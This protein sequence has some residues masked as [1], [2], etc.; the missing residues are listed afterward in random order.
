[1][2]NLLV[3]IQ[4]LN[5]TTKNNMKT[6]T[7]YAEKKAKQILN[8]LQG[9]T[10]GIRITAILILLLMGVNNAWATNGTIS[11]GGI[12]YLNSGGSTIWD[13]ASAWFSV[14]FMDANK[15]TTKFVSMTKVTG[16]Y[17]YAT[18]PTGTWTYV[19][20]VR[21]NPTDK[22]ADWTNVW[23]QTADLETQSDKNLYTI[24]G[25]SYGSW[26]TYQPTATGSLVASS[27]N[28]VAKNTNITLTPSIS[29][30]TYNVLKSTSY[31]ISPSSGAT[32]SN[33]TF[34]ATA[35]GSYTVT[36][37]I[38][39]NA[40]G[41]TNITKTATATTTI[42]VKPT[43]TFN[44]NGG[45]GSMSAQTVSYNTNT[46]L[47]ANTFTAPVG[48]TF[49]GWNTKTDGKGTAYA[50]GTSY[51]FTSDLTLYA[52]WAE[53]PVNSHNITYTAQATGWTYG[54]SNPTT[55][56]EDATVTFEVIPTTGYTVTVTSS[57]VSLSN[58]GNIYTFIMPND[59][60]TI[61]VSATAKTYAIEFDN[62]GGEGGPS[63]VTATY[64]AAMPT[65][66]P[67]T[68][69]GY[70][71]NGYFDATSGGTK[72]YNANG[73]S[74]KNWDK[75][76]ATTLYAQWTANKY[77]VKFN[78]N[79]GSGTMSN[80][81]FTYDVPQQLTPNAFTRSGYTFIGWSNSSSGNVV[82]T[83]RQL[84]N[85]LTTNNNSTVNIYAIW[86]KKTA[87]TVYLKPSDEW[88]NDNARFAV[89]YWKDSENGWVDMEDVGC[90]GE[91]YK[92]DIPVK[93]TDIIFCRM[94][95]NATEYKFENVW[96]QSEDLQVPN[97]DKVLY[98]IGKYR[99]DKL[100]LIPNAWETDGANERYAAYFFGNGN[101]WRSMT[102]IGDGT[103]ECEKPS[104][105]STVI[106]CRM[107]G[108]NS[109]NDWGNKWTQT[110]D[111]SIPNNGDNIYRIND[112][113]ETYG[114]AKSG[115]TW[116]AGETSGW[117]TYTEPDI[118]IKLVKTTNGTITLGTIISGNT[119]KTF[120]T[121][122]NSTYVLNVA[123]ADGYV[124]ASC[125]ITMGNNSA[126]EGVG[127][128]TYTFCGD[129]TITAEFAKPVNLTEQRV[130]G[131][132]LVNYG[133]V[134]GNGTKANP[135]TLYSDE[136]VRITVTALPT[137]AG[138]T[139]YYKFGLNEEQT[140]NV[141]EWKGI[142]GSTATNLRV[143][144]YYKNANGNI[145]DEHM[146]VTAYY[147]FIPLPFY[148]MT[149]PNKEINIEDIKA[150]KNILVQF[151]SE[152][153]AT[154][155]LYVKKDNE[156][157][158]F[159]TSISDEDAYDYT[160][161]VPNNIGLCVLHFIARASTPVHGRTFEIDADVAIYKNVI[162]KVNDTEGW[163]KDVYLWRD[164]SGDVL[165]SWPGNP[166]LQNFGTWRV[167]SVKYPYYD[168]FIV[169]NGQT[170][171][172]VQTISWE[173]PE[174]DKCYEL[175][176][177]EHYDHP[178]GE[179]EWKYGLEE[180]DCP[181]DLIVS[182]IEN[183][184]ISVGEEKVIMPEIF[185]GLGHQLSDVTMD[186]KTTDSESKYVRL[187]A[188]GTNI[189]LIGKAVGTFEVTVTYTLG[190]LTV[191]KTFE[192]EITSSN[193]LTIT[194]KVPRQ[195]NDGNFQIG[196]EN[197]E[198]IKIYYEAYGLSTAS[199]P[200]NYLGTFDDYYYMQ[201][202][203][204]FGNGPDIDFVVYWQDRN[205]WWKKAKR[206]ENVKTDGCYVI[207][208]G[209]END[210]RSITL[211]A[212]GCKFYQVKVRMQNGKTYQSNV[213]FAATD[214]LSFFAPG[215]N[216]VG[217]N[218]GAVIVYENNKAVKLI[219]PGKFETSDV[220]TASVNE[221]DYTLTNIAPYTGNFYIRTWGTDG[222]IS[223]KGWNSVQDWTDGEKA[224]R[225][226]TEF[227]SR[228]GEFYN[229]YW[230]QAMN[231]GSFDG[232]D[233]SA[234]VANDYNDDLAGKLLQDK[235]TDEHGD[236]KLGGNVKII[237]VRFGYNPRTNYFA[238]AVLQG[239]EYENYLNL[240]CDNAYAD[241]ECTKKLPY[242]NHNN[243]TENKFRD[244]SS[245]V[246]ERDIYVNI[247][248]NTPSA[249]LYV[250]AKSP[251]SDA[252][253]YNHLLGYVTNEVTGEETETP[254]QKTVIGSGTD[255]GVY[256]VRVVYDFK[257]NRMIAVWELDKDIEI[258]T[259]KTI[260][261]DIL[262]IRKDNEAVPQITLTG[263]G[264]INNL[265]SLFFA[266]ELHRGSTEKDERHEEQYMFTLP[267]DCVV[268]SISGLHGYMELWGI[269]RY[270][271]DLRAQKGWYAETAT[272]WEWLTPKDILRAG[273]G[274]LLAFDKK[275][276]PWNE[277]EVDKT[278]AN[279]NIIEGQKETISML[280]L[281]FPSIGSGFD[282]QQQSAEQL[283][284]TY[285]NHP[286]TLTLHDRN[287]QDSN[288]KMIGTT[289]YNNATVKEYEKDNDPEY[290][291]LEGG[292]APKFR[293]TYSYEFDNNNNRKSYTY[294]PELGS[295]EGVVY[296]SFYGYMVQF[297]GTITWN[298]INETVPEP[299]AAPRRAQAE[300]SSVT[301]RL[302]LANTEGE[303]QDQTFVALDEDGTTTFDQN[304]DLNKVF[305]SGKPNIYTLSESIPFAGNT[306]PMEE[307]IVPVGVKIDAEGEYTFRMPD[308]TEGMVVELIDY[309]RDITTNLLLFDYTVTLPAGSNESRFALHI[310]PNKS[311]VTTGVEN[312]GDKAKGIEKY[313]IDGKLM[314]RT[315]EG[316]FDAQG[317]RL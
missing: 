119:D 65:I 67:P 147:K 156:A 305:N 169:N 279:G 217:R 317:R 248:N 1:M 51:K 196:W 118:T 186:I 280:R 303:K 304:K 219:E 266:M 231:K 81:S 78:A 204:P 140:E 223:N 212:N 60:V 97:D 58:N 224:S 296:K 37:T 153:K 93:Y 90:T 298:P 103:Y 188:S 226:F 62:E 191:E 308:G 143:T 275:N 106:F 30:T 220:Y 165:T 72:Y 128:D 28:N 238:R 168:R 56:E 129:A 256:K 29:P 3:T 309:E 43:I 44:A 19:I 38:T 39:Y 162:I 288:W 281:Y 282:L 221:D 160:H 151:R 253:V 294:A 316:V 48:Y 64:A 148:L 161:D 230:V 46:T 171:G 149:D 213:G 301:M 82:Y 314:I 11:G 174:N 53:I 124:L 237:N 194:V 173:V 198:D 99:S 66:T 291:E 54:N 245:W 47:S 84:V 199:I 297:A 57:D 135:Y 116:S 286:C 36:A 290:D 175:V 178:V 195:N 176:A 268:G 35:G 9:Y 211:E 293:Y 73:S 105:F 289:S 258:S 313:L 273:E 312:V 203:V 239:S 202:Q 152:T 225:T 89:Y 59:D 274:Y 181:A 100:Y 17:Y 154:V 23:N 302:E 285:P 20:F 76:A 311:G 27:S 70:T 120:T 133:W 283:T 98:K 123:P 85:N 163:V 127:G 126:I 132:E 269:Q 26:S 144:A 24:T 201:A 108:D 164:G 300:R 158:T 276:A 185:V 155:S 284:V 207:S 16:N 52:Q 71:F 18:V 278:D 260:N 8:L 193:T 122:I 255:N 241:K 215:A 184:T 251:R 86:E 32:I 41:F 208:Q 227:V 49:N 10:K 183:V 197:T 121:S 61:E 252:T 306:L 292:E 110:N 218:A 22:T 88:K 2:T 150:G 272:F 40:K 114:D 112:D 91:Y 267:F 111:L 263:D 74:A 102:Y 240:H 12:I 243:I 50:A 45:S 33:N 170:E 109:T 190:G 107:N 172:V 310:Q 13:Q 209:I 187:L 249:S 14:Y 80:Q 180:A 177:P 262:F 299:L 77:S 233:V 139:A 130:H 75:T 101:T 259:N 206:V 63:S 205:S 189:I 115:G 182:D 134:G 265:Q 25:W 94:N 307:V 6:F 315:A 167:F 246:Y 142:D 21:N 287:L 216:E 210:A 257:T 159:L 271:G 235:N 15:S 117:T 277:I 146:G 244:I 229:H 7:T 261:A 157:E 222:D 55:A 236:I 87:N 95:P 138:K 31:S 270:R 137:V 166:V 79:S 141:F 228:E 92:A 68:R 232:K 192:V 83:N 145:S 179:D 264:R 113:A 200:M 214:I 247:T 5:K 42:T 125:R 254:I 96:N 131:G 295:G 242:G 250:E 136:A 69:T 4:P 104:G 34:K 234:C